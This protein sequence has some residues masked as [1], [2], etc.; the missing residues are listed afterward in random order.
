MAEQVVSLR[1][2]ITS[3]GTVRVLR[4]DADAIAGLGTAARQAG[5]QVEGELNKMSGLFSTLQSK[6]LDTGSAMRTVAA[7]ASGFGVAFSINAVVS[8][9][10]NLV[11]T[12][13]GFAASLEQSHIAI[14][15]LLQGT[16]QLIGANNKLLDPTE[17]WT[18]N[19][20]DAHK[21]Q[22][23]LLEL[24]I[25]T[26]GSYQEL[27]DVF[28]SVLAYSRGQKATLDDQLKLSQGLLNV[29]KLLGL[30]GARQEAEARQ[31]LELNT[32][33]GQQ[34]LAILGVSVEQA[35]IW[36]Q[37][38]TLVQELNTRLAV[39]NK[40]AESAALTW[41]GITS[42]VQSF[43]SVLAAQ[44]FEGVF[45][46]FKQILI[47]VGQELSRLK[48]QGQITI[49]VDDADLRKLGAT[50][51]DIYNTMLRISA[52]VVKVVVEITSGIQQALTEQTQ[53]G[54]VKDISQAL[55]STMSVSLESTKK[56]LQALGAV[57]SAVW[58]GLAT[59]A[60]DF[61]SLLL[62]V[63]GQTERANVAQEAALNANKRGIDSL[64]SAFV[65]GMDKI[66]ASTQKATDTI[67]KMFEAQDI[68]IKDMGR[69]SAA[70]ALT[71]EQLKQIADAGIRIA[72]LKAQ[73][74]TQLATISPAGNLQQS[75][76][77]Q[78]QLLDLQ[79]KQKE[80][81]SRS[82][83][84]TTALKQEGVLRRAAIYEQ[85]TQIFITQERNKVQ[86]AQASTTARQAIEQARVQSTVAGYQ[87]E[88]S[89]ITEQIN[90]LQLQQ[91]TE[92]ERSALTQQK[93]KL[94]QDIAATQAQGARQQAAATQAN[95]ALY[96]R[97]IADLTTRRN[98]IQQQPT[99]AE[100]DIQVRQ[101][102][103]AIAATANQIETER[104][105]VIQFTTQAT[106]EFAKIGALKAKAD[107]DFIKNLN[108]QAQALA[109][110]AAAT[111]EV[112]A[113][114][115]QQAD[116]RLKERASLLDAQS[117]SAQAYLGLLKQQGAG[118]DEVG[119][120]LQNVLELERARA[121]LAVQ[122]AQ[123][124][125]S[126]SQSRLAGLAAESAA[127]DDII[128]QQRAH[129]AV[130]KEVLEQQ[131]TL[132]EDINN[133]IGKIVNAQGNVAVATEKANTA[134]INGQIA[135]SQYNQEVTRT[136]L[137]TTQGLGQAL[138][139][140][141]TGILQGTQ[142]WGK[143]FEDLGQG[144]G[145]KLF[146]SILVGKNDQFDVPIIGNINNLL[147]GSQGGI[148]GSLF[149]QGGGVLSS[150]FGGAF[151]GGFVDNFGSGFGAAVS[152]VFDAN[153]T[154]WTQVGGAASSW[155]GQSLFSGITSQISSSFPVLGNFM[156]SLSGTLTNPLVLGIGAALLAAFK[157]SDLFNQPGRIETEKKSISK[158]FED[159]FSGTDFKTFKEKQVAGAFVTAGDLGRSATT[160][161]ALY[162][163]EAGEGSTQGTIIRAGGQFLANLFDKQGLSAE[164][165]KDKILELAQGMKFNLVD[166]L[167]AVNGLMS[168]FSE[169]QGNNLLSL[170]QF[171]KELAD[172]KKNL[173]DYGDTATLT[174]KQLSDLAVQHGNTGS[175]LVLYSDL[176]AG[177]IDLATGFNA[178]IDSQSLALSLL[179]E[180]F[181]A[182]TQAQGS[183]GQ[184]TIDLSK[185]IQTGTLSIEEAIVE[186]NKI[187]ASSGQAALA[188]TD[189]Q[190]DPAKVQAQVQQLLDIT[191]GMTD[192]FSQIGAGFADAMVK[193]MTGEEI[194]VQFED[195]LKKQ[196]ASA[197]AGAFTAALQASLQS[198][199]IQEYLSELSK[200]I[201]SYASGTIGQDLFT[202]QYLALQEKYGPI[203]EQF[204]Q[205]LIEAGNV[206]H[207]LLNTF[208]LLPDTI[209]QA[210]NSAD[211]LVNKIK[212]L[213]QQIAE[214]GQKQLQ[215]RLDVAGDL[216]Q[217]GAL[218]A[219]DVARTREQLLRSTL[220]GLGQQQAARQQ[221][222][223]AGPF[224]HV[225]DE[226]LT[227]AITL[228]QQIRQAVVE[229]Y[230]VEEQAINATLQ[231]TID[232]INQAQGAREAAIR[233]D[234][235]QR[236]QDLQD[237]VQARQ[238]EKQQVSDLYQVQLD[239]LQRLLQIAQDFAGVVQTA[240]QA[241]TGLVTG[242]QTAFS[243][244]EQFQILQ[245]QEQ[246]LRNQLASAQPGNQPGLI[247]D[248][249]AN[250]QQQLASSPYQIT[251]LDYFQQF[252]NTLKEIEGL[253]SLAQES[254][255]SV[256]QIQQQ[257]LET[258]LSQKQQLALIDASIQDLQAQ[259]QTL[260]QLETAAIT[261]SQQIAA[262]QIA[263][264]QQQT[265]QQIVEMRE[266]VAS[267]IVWLGTLEAQLLAE[268]ATRL[269]A[270]KAIAEQQL[271]SLVGSEEAQ[272][273]LAS[274]AQ[275]NL[276][277]LA[278]IN[279]TLSSIDQHLLSFLD[280]Q[281]AH[282]EGEQGADVG[283]RE[284]RSL[285][286]IPQ[287]SS[288][289][290][291]AP[292][293]WVGPTGG[294]RSAPSVSIVIQNLTIVGGSGS[295]DEMQAQA[296]QIW[297]L[298]RNAAIAELEQHGPLARAI[299]L[300]T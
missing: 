51:A 112:T 92:A 95:I 272:M 202:A 1:V 295:A 173:S 71:A 128:A 248:L 140:I 130:T 85:E 56:E 114:N 99:G 43:G 206:G 234:F 80:A 279:G 59:G 184:A 191:K 83:A 20:E 97:E 60:N 153:Q 146:K 226:A 283:V 188:L 10:R 187:R 82:E 108:D 14:A 147:G 17:A 178:A 90:L 180:Q 190:I 215:L 118:L 106:T 240:Q 214:I 69:F 176:L 76:Q 160:L 258:Q 276:I 268:Q 193:G 87:N 126:I 109:R 45:S 48:D 32:Q 149:S 239:N 291:F 89:K 91:G 28:A 152:N 274:G 96:E 198:T 218:A 227:Q 26:L 277:E 121:A 245:A 262:Q 86:A 253:Q 177:A 57:G 219:T 46:G 211:D 84:E 125:L 271:I 233:A 63:D 286:V 236:R 156:G 203:V 209:S 34:T 246:N 137:L 54:L 292:S 123:L 288:P 294:M 195:A 298:V 148:L 74:A 3:A 16:T 100:R 33:M 41:E 39:Y 53:G 9:F 168:Q 67:W 242:S 81:E 88:I 217:I 256:P 213:N 135:W 47:G 196:L 13:I 31:I 24:N 75:T 235:A 61:Y 299:E 11:E 289:V 145:T 255:K 107:V 25:Q 119:L 275:A 280:M 73:A 18:Q 72:Q 266:K 259:A 216:G 131:K 162:A 186:L 265:S 50:L 143:M 30:E 161:G 93:L 133:T 116:D 163:K 8:G 185:Q 249:I 132:N 29:G 64:I 222:N 284:E 285:S 55:G 78:L 290:S 183:T 111:A 189:F 164:Q 254:A 19:L 263:N 247:R 237:A 70:T 77:A 197:I 171:Q 138:E 241:V 62:R 115:F 278:N 204:K 113:R 252:N 6:I 66:A 273:L 165:A 167:N 228:T 42:T 287:A 159:I 12:S 52:T 282:G 220:V 264:A 231:Q 182:V 174:A 157:L 251:S 300:N 244:P 22:G 58:E 267:Q 129:G 199:G 260:S 232:S 23:Q 102:D 103:Q 293:Q 229:R 230:G 144:L 297:R 221:P 94:E 37:H 208:G 151:Q 169:H 296:Q 243:R 155:F 281:T 261:A 250:L 134:A 101:I 7:I 44:Q 212:E 150:L 124:E 27:Q 120:Q 238:Q 5:Q 181:L 68:L 122:Q 127:L 166:S 200:L 201:A 141:S 192:F 223:Q 172:A 139:Q 224:T 210:T 170:E 79:Q 2:E 49:G 98:L 142:S 36:K 136:A 40:L 21:I 104:A 15:A 38:G 257:I 225:T 117:S 207:D 35:R 65:P 270:Q 269:E 175:K 154:V 205:R 4:D 179:S 194:G 158:Y 105:K 110:D